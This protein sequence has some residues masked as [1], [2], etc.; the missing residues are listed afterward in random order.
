MVHLDVGHNGLL[1]W[2]D[3]DLQMGHP[4]LSRL[5]SATLAEHWREGQKIETTPQR[6]V[7]LHCSHRALLP[8][9]RAECPG[10]LA[11]R[12]AELQLPQFHFVATAQ[13][14]STPL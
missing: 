2:R 10:G 11:A 3:A 6:P 9:E 8:G 5:P 14:R 1:A 4:Q 7:R 12:P 13:L